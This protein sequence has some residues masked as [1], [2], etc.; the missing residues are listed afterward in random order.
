MNLLHPPIITGEYVLLWALFFRWG[1]WSLQSL[2]NVP[3][4]KWQRQIGKGTI[5]QFGFRLW[6][7][8]VN[9]H[10]WDWRAK[11]CPPCNCRRQS[12]RQLGTRPQ[13]HGVL[14]LHA[15]QGS[16]L[17][18]IQ[19]PGKKW[20]S[21]EFRVEEAGH[22][23]VGYRRIPSAWDLDGITHKPSFLCTEKTCPRH[24]FLKWGN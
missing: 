21:A 15:R 16:V 6:T 3:A 18:Q 17:C 8:R 19:N 12:Q 23:S 24:S 4:N 14:C 7:L 2:N 22:L 20:D 11:L 1:N 5:W 10:M 13:W 9:G